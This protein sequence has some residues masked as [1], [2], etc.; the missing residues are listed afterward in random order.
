MRYVNPLV[1]GSETLPGHL[2]REHVRRRTEHVETPEA[3]TT[4]AVVDQ[5]DSGPACDSMRHAPR[6]KR[7]P[8]TPQYTPNLNAFVDDPDALPW[9]YLPIS[10][11]S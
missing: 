1:E 6:R 10:L 3:P 2:R 9:G 11:R 5:N 4:Y 8:T 7:L